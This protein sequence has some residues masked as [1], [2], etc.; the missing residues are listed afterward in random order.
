MLKVFPTVFF[1]SSPK[2]VVFRIP[3]AAIPTFFCAATYANIFF[4]RGGNMTIHAIIIQDGS[5]PNYYNTLFREVQPDVY[6]WK[7]EEG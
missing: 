1:N 6:G 3:A 4:A 7:L 5:P 2:S